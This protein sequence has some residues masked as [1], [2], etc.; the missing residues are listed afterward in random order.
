MNEFIIPVAWSRLDSMIDFLEQRLSRQ[1]VP[2]VLRLRTQLVLEE[3]FDAAMAAPG[4][5]AARIRCTLPA[6]LTVL[7]QCRSTD[8][9]FALDWS[10]LQALENASCTYGLK[11]MM[12]GNNCQIL[13]GQR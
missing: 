9:D 4:A 13:I 7:L 8:P 2:T 1:G 11:Y 12:S 5:A 3:V 10:G 6:P